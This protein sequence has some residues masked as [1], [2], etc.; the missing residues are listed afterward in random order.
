MR[1]CIGWS[2]TPPIGAC[3]AGAIE[4]FHQSDLNRHAEF[5]TS[6]GWGFLATLVDEGRKTRRAQPGDLTSGAG[7][8]VAM[9][10]VKQFDEPRGGGESP[11]ARFSLPED[12]AK[13]TETLDP[14]FTDGQDGV[15]RESQRAN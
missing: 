12:A 7:S 1:F 15:V 8:E 14:A 4:I 11:A 10:H 3:L 13:Q 2:P 6:A 9:F 5:R